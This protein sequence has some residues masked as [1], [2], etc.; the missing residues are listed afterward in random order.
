MNRFD[1]HALYWCRE[2]GEW[3][4]ETYGEEEEDI[5]NVVI[6]R[7]SVFSKLMFICFQMLWA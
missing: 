5:A 6:K 4:W 7:W 1:E 3:D 2:E